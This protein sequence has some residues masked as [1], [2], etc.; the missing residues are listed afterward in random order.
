MKYEILNSESINFFEEKPII[1][2][3]NRDFYKC[4][5]KKNN[6]RRMKSL[7]D[8]DLYYITQDYREINNGA[9]LTINFDKG[10]KNILFFEYL[11]K[12]QEDIES[13]EYSVLEFVKRMNYNIN[14]FKKSN[15]ES[16]YFNISI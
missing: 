14:D 3:G 7:N 1:K 16:K 10:R 4:N 13:V 5:F 15:D 8:T 6:L 12:P 2:I 11:R 9:Y